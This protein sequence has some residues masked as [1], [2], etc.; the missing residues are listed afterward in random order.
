MMNDCSACR[1]ASSAE[2]HKHHANSRCMH[3]VLRER[4]PPLDDEGVL[5][6]VQVRP[7][8]QVLVSDN[9]PNLVLVFG[10][11]PTL[12]ELAPRE[13][14]GGVLEHGDAVVCHE[15]AHHELALAALQS[16]AE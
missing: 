15:V 14:V 4:G 6:Q 9:V 13:A 12:Q 2:L 3:V 10:H 7:D 16:V 1:I 11:L 8:E 5:V